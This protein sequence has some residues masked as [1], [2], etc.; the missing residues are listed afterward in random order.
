MFLAITCSSDE[1]S[2]DGNNIDPIIGVWDVNQVGGDSSCKSKLNNYRFKIIPNGTW[3]S[4]DEI[5]GFWLN[6]AETNDFNNYSQSYRWT[7]LYP[8]KRR[9]FLLHQWLQ[10]KPLLIHLYHCPNLR[11]IK[12]ILGR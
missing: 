9:V 8:H 3:T 12:V 2:D 1:M 7:N 10:P 11:S 5:D 4:E 6:L